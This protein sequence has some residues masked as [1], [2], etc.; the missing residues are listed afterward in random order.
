MDWSK[1]QEVIKVQTSVQSLLSCRVATVK[2]PVAC[3]K[4]YGIQYLLGLAIDARLQESIH[5][6]LID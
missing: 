3:L 5:D 6:V 2:L 4:I 1:F